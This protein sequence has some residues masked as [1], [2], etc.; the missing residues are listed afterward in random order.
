MKLLAQSG[1]LGVWS[2]NLA[3]PTSK[4]GQQDLGSSML[5]LYL[6]HLVISTLHK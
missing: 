3:L 2:L 1:T 6:F 4:E 5:T